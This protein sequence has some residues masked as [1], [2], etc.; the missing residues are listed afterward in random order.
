MDFMTFL[1]NYLSFV[2]H[3]S[4]WCTLNL[5]LSY[6]S[7]VITTY[8]DS[9]FNVPGPDTIITPGREDAPVVTDAVSILGLGVTALY[10]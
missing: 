2:P 4:C 1:A 9:E 7:L 6:S 10:A 8:S 5:K 3:K